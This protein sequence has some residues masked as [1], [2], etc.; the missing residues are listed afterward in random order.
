[1]A[2][3]SASTR[4]SSATSDGPPR[5]LSLWSAPRSR[6]TAFLRMMTERG[7]YAVVHEPFSHLVDFGGCEVD[8][9]QVTDERQLISTLRRM[10]ERGPVFFKDTTDF[11]YPGLL[12]DTDFLRDAAH[13]FIIREPAEVIA[14]HYALNR[15]L[16]CEDVG[17]ARLSEIYDAVAAAIGR[18]PVVI[19]SA[20]LVKAPEQ[21]V[22]AYCAAVGIPFMERAL[23]W[24]ATMLPAWR[25]TR[26]WHELTSR[27]TYFTEAGSSYRDTADNNP[28]LARYLDHHLP[29]YEKLRNGRLR[30]ERA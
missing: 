25:K 30:I 20:D 2:G 19:D 1:M 9:V 28:L 11:A 29:Y 4:P 13:T 27:T 26:R 18:P 14:S 3:S 12:A 21:T 15:E 10:S 6:S 16:K 17:I 24:D 5:I 23:F 8:G 7:D 22:R